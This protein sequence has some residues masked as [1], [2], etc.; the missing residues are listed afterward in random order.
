MLR[1]AACAGAR[2]LRGG[3]GARRLS[4]WATLDV[5]R[6]AT[7]VEIKA[8]YRTLCKRWHPDVCSEAGADAKMRA[9][10][11]AYASL[12]RHGGAAA[13]AEAEADFDARGEEQG[14]R[15]KASGFGFDFVGNT[16]F[17]R[18]LAPRS[19]ALLVPALAALVWFLAPQKERV[20][21]AEVFVD[22]CWLNPATRKWEPP[23]PW[24]PAF[25]AAKAQGHLRRILR[26]EL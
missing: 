15:S 19:L 14:P 20:R 26:S 6:A 13:A 1:R 16:V 9:I 11:E 3:G 7:Q 24:L 25:R 21:D 10:N 18:W 4:H 23:T 5:G 22:D 12:T 8:A 2:G 17:E